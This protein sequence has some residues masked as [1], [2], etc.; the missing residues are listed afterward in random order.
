LS[1]GRL[2]TTLLEELTKDATGFIGLGVISAAAAANLLKAKREVAVHD[3]R[4]E[5]AELGRNGLT[6]RRWPK[7]VT[8]SSAVCLIS[9]RSIS[10]PGAGRRP[11]RSARGRGLRDVDQH[12]RSRPATT[13]CNFARA[14]FVQGE[15]RA[16]RLGSPGE[17]M[18]VVQHDPAAPDSW[19]SLAVHGSLVRYRASADPRLYLVPIG[20]RGPDCSAFDTLLRVPVST[21]MPAVGVT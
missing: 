6:R 12:P 8:S 4:P 16:D 17:R 21:G 3:V 14:P 20:C 1:E 9:A 5:A 11:S 13:C 15:R 7:A 19:R 18:L 2:G 10:S